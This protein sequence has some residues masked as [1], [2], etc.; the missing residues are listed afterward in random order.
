MDMLR[1]PVL[2]ASYVSR[3]NGLHPMIRFGF[4][5]FRASVCRIYALA[6][7]ALASAHAALTFSQRTTTHGIAQL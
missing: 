2:S 5:L 1:V 4:L 7:G 3:G 6:S